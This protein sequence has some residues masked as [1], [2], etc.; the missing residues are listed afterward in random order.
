L[1]SGILTGKY[2]DGLQEGTRFSLEG[3]EWLRERLESEQGQRERASVKKLKPIADDLGVSRAQL[4]LAWALKNPHVSTVITGASRAEQVRENMKAV[5][6]AEKI[7]PDVMEA[8][9]GVLGNKPAALEL[10]GRE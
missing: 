1:A 4:A 7:T 9:D 10:F 8:I 3:Y 6:V 5:D 2:D